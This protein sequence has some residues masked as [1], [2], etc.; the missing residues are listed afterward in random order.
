MPP[1]KL[2]VLSLFSIKSL[3]DVSDF[4]WHVLLEQMRMSMVGS[5]RRNITGIILLDG[6]LSS[7][8][9]QSLLASE[10]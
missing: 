5:K 7:R 2:I 4:E 10:S 3:L 1:A 9:L 6:N 8:S